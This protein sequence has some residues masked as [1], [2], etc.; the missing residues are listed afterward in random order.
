MPLA[1]LLV[2]ID[3]FKLYNDHYGHVAGD[4]CL[5]LVAQALAGCVRRADEMA[6][7]YGGEEFVL[8]LPGTSL[9]AAREVAQ[10]CLDGIEALALPHASSC[11]ASVLTISIGVASMV[12]VAGADPSMLVAAADAALYRAKKEGRNQFGMQPETAA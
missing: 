1:L 4:H 3:H 11:T 10:L 12:P 8:L 6:A 5:R 7:R 9:D 2:D